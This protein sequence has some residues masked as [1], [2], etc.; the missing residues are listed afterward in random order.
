IFLSYPARY[1]IVHHSLLRSCI[2]VSLSGG[3][4]GG[5][6]RRRAAFALV[7]ASIEGDQHLS[8]PRLSLPRIETGAARSASPGTSQRPACGSE[9]RP[10]PGIADLPPSYRGRRAPAGERRARVGGC[11]SVAA[12]HA[13]PGSRPPAAG[14]GVGPAG[15]AAGGHTAIP[16]G[17]AA[18]RRDVWKV[19]ISGRSDDFVQASVAVLWGVGEIGGGFGLRAG[20]RKV[21]V[22][23]SR[24]AVAIP[25]FDELVLAGRSHPAASHRPSPPRR[26]VPL[27][28]IRWA[29]SFARA[30]LPCPL[31]ASGPP[32]VIL[33]VQVMRFVS[34]EFNP[35]PIRS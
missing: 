7:G 34:L 11:L 3:G 4:G 31:C 1:C 19:L 22:A 15:S 16:S 28:V 32:C 24:E 8:L 25:G 26:A 5:D 27:L 18:G 12:G 21:G 6:C 23:V 9:A 10:D 35:L 2:A 29:A 33:L 17:R 30:P 14:A 20:L 13:S